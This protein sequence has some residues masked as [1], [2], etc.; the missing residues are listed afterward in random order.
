M[1]RIHIVCKN[2]KDIQCILLF[3]MCKGQF[4][5][6]PHC[7]NYIYKDMNVHKYPRSSYKIWQTN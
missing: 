4:I 1:H 7:F 2:I 6:R 3:I 5:A